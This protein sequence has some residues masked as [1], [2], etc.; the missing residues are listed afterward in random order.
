M[1]T[2]IRVPTLGESVTE[3]TIG[4]GSRRSAMPSVDEP[5][6]ELET[7]KVTIEVPAPAPAPWRN[8]R[9][10]RRDGRGQRAAGMIAEGEGAAAPA[11]AETAPPRR[12]APSRL[13]AEAPAAEKPRAGGHAMPA[14]SAQADGRQDRSPETVSGSGKRGQVLKG[15][16]LDAIGKGS[17]PA[18]APA[19]ARPAVFGRRR[20]REERVRMTRCARPSPGA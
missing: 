9:Q 6:V 14:P 4:N 10:G 20:P 15:D 19:A 17:A 3:A 18:A 7:D 1:A 16:V 5:L 12:K 2:E 8:H 11:K 13:P